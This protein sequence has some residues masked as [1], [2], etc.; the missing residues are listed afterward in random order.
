MTRAPKLGVNFYA[1]QAEDEL[2]AEQAA[3]DMLPYFTGKSAC[4]RYSID[5]SCRAMGR[6]LGPE[7]EDPLISSL[8]PQ[9]NPSPRWRPQAPPFP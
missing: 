4:G 7:G 1:I 5:Y 9:T 6:T 2:V 8:R 3:D